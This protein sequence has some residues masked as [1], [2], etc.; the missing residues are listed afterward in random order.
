[1]VELAQDHVQWWALILVVLNF[2]VLLPDSYLVSKMDLREI[3]CEMGRWMELAQEH[4]P[5]AGF[6]ICGVE[7]S[8]FATRGLVN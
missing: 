6:G 1:M 4:V 7:P 2:L 5:M 8:G 3:G